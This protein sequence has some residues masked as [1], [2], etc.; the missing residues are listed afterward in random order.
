MA[1]DL[2]KGQAQI[3][4]LRGNSIRALELE[5]D[6]EVQAARQ[7]GDSAQRLAQII[8]ESEEKIRQERG[9]SLRETGFA[10]P[11]TGRVAQFVT[12]LEDAQHNLAEIFG[13]RG[14]ADPA[15]GLAAI[16]EHLGTLQARIEQ[17]R[18]V[19]GPFSQKE[20]E[21]QGEINR[22]L[23]RRNDLRAQLE[24]INRGGATGPPAA[25][26][27]EIELSREADFRRATI[28]RA[29]FLADIGRGHRD[30]VRGLMNEELLAAEERWL[31]D[32]TAEN[33][34]GITSLEQ[35]LSTLSINL[36]DETGRAIA[37]AFDTA[38]DSILGRTQGFA[39]T[40]LSILKSLSG[41]IQRI[42]IQE[43]AQKVVD[44]L[45]GVIKGGGGGAQGLIGQGLASLRGFFGGGATAPVQQLGSLTAAAPG[46]TGGAPFLTKGVQA[47]AQGGGFLSSLGRVLSLATPPIAA[48]AGIGGIMSTLTGGSPL[49]STLGGGLVGLGGMLGGQALGTALGT[50]LSG[51]LGTAAPQ[52]LGALGGPIGMVIGA[53]AG[54][55]LGGLF[56]KKKRKDPVRAAIRAWA[57]Q[58]LFPTVALVR[59]EMER[60]RNI[61]FTR[62]GP[63][64]SFLQSFG[65]G[66]TSATIRA[67]GFQAGIPQRMVA[68]VQAF[69]KR[70][71]EMARKM[72]EVIGDALAEGFKS[73]TKRSGWREFL[74]NLREGIADHVTEGIVK[75]V[76]KSKAITKLVAPIFELV[77]PL[78]KAL[79]KGDLAKAE[80]LEAEIGARIKALEPGL[81][82]FEG[83]FGD[84]FEMVENIRRAGRPRGEL[85]E[86]VPP[87]FLDDFARVVP[88]AQ[89]GG[90]V[91]RG[92]LVAVHAG[93]RIVP[94]QESSRSSKTV[95]E[96]SFGAEL[97][98][99]LQTL[100]SAFADI[101]EKKEFT[102]SRF[103]E[104][105]LS[106]L[107]PTIPQAE[108]MSRLPDALQTLQPDKALENALS[109]MASIPQFPMGGETMRP[110][111]S[112][113]D[114]AEER[115]IPAVGRI[116]PMSTQRREFIFN[117]PITVHGAA[118]TPQEAAGWGTAIA[119]GLERE[120]R[121]TLK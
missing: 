47:A 29:R 119:W 50:S 110:A 72:T 114:H 7:R 40:M 21:A 46:S 25:Q 106:G 96:I 116:E 65:P 53:L 67:M 77:P 87:H 30:T 105:A 16:E 92:G 71:Q 98:S 89:A 112:L 36:W 22:L 49:G 37:G 48:G 57:Q 2:L 68:E 4:E 58:E 75:A 1:L 35:D 26:A 78:T 61:G 24:E 10:D 109:F 103:M 101:G 15:A 64:A 6:A 28:E 94:P 55:A 100:K 44:W 20:I 62:L 113:R 81:R 83:T 97:L 93:E 74:S 70:M 52:M 69:I 108:R 117:T 42:L 3:E 56:G 104:D 107:I 79:K 102:M 14:G 17:I 45:K 90:S 86:T 27:R 51:V 66:T 43:S 5:R 91:A 99:G 34:R 31:R 39:G 18:A 82:A 111:T 32:P 63:G 54:S 60:L 88:K 41:S 95:V 73:A 118:S 11:R 38:L 23:E 115:V 121:R 13:A 9:K 19:Q 80:G 59:S 33:L 85:W 84:I 120:L 8:A 76:A 12:T